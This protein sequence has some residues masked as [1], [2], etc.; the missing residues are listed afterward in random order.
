MVMDTAEVSKM[1]P[2]PPESLST[3]SVM[4]GKPRLLYSLVSSYPES[5]MEA[6]NLFQ[7]DAKKWHFDPILW[8][9]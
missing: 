7:A 3:C 9:K 2:S 6:T 5:N 8:S 4:T 1:A